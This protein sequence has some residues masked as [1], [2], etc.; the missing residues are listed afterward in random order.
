LK[1]ASKRRQLNRSKV[2][3]QALGVLQVLLMGGQ[4]NLSSQLLVQM[5]RGV[6][7]VLSRVQLM[8]RG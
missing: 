3:V 6:L 4:V 1:H 8:T 5:G 2:K 7:M